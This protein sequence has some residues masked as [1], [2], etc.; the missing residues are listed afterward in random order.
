MKKI[1]I[2][3]V[4]FICFYPGTYVYGA[5]ENEIVSID[6]FDFSESGQVLKEAG[7]DDFNVKNIINK[8]ITGDF[9]SV[10]KSCLNIIYRKTIGDVSFIYH[11][12]GNLVLVAVLSAFF[13]NFASVFSQDNVSE[14]A[15]YI[16]YLVAITLMITLFDSFCVIAGDFIK[17]LMS[18]MYGITPTYFLSVALVGQV[19]AAG[20][21]QLTLVI[22]SVS[23]FVFL[24]VIIPLI[25]IYVAVS[26]VNNISK[27]D[28]LSRTA[29][30]I[31]NLV[32]FLTKLFVGI[33]TGLNVIQALVLPSIDG[34]KNTT[35]RKFVGTLPVVGD[36]A[37]AMSSIVLGSFHLIKNTIGGFAIIAIIVLCMVPFLKIQ[38]YSFSVQIAAAFI[39]PIS[40]KRITDSLS[41]VSVG[42]KMLSRIIISGGILFVISIAIICMTTGRS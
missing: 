13:T 3:L 15:F 14:T 5:E 35:L 22:I 30:V 18:F 8:I 9:Y 17:L 16:C 26:I 6:D 28:F 31:K 21:Y 4:L 37:D 34:V 41:S 25:K 33:V 38:I 2:I 23:E 40:D 1:I 24:H 39:Q 11:V 29:H 12:L 7:Y 32:D 42:T 27:E 10:F 20:F 19:S 36:G